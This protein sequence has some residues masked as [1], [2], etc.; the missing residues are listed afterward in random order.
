MAECRIVCY[1]PG[2]DLMV[3]TFQTVIIGSG[4]AGLNCAEHLHELGVHDIAIVTDRLGAGT[5]ANSG[6]DKQTYYK[7]G[8][9]G[10]VPDSPVQFARTLTEGGMCHGD[11]AYV[12][13][14]G[15]VPEFVHLVRNGV[16]FP[17]NE[18]G[19]YVG[20]KTDHDPRQRAT[21]AGP[22]TSMQMVAKSLDQVRRAAIPIFDGFEVVR[23]LTEGHG[24][25]KRIVGALAVEKAR[26]D[27]GTFGLTVF[28]AENVVLATGGPGE[29]YEAS[30][31]PPGQTGGLGLALEIGCVAHNLTESQFGIAS[32]GFRW[33]LSGTYQQVIPCYFSVDGD[34]GSGRNASST[35]Y[36]LNDYFPSMKAEAT[37]IFLKGC[38]WPFHAERLRDC[39]SSVIDI[40]VHNE[41]A[42]GRQ[43]YLDFSR[44]P[45]ADQGLEEFSPDDLEPEARDYLAACGADQPTPYE[46]LRHV[47]PQAI[48]LYAE[49][50]VDLREPLEIAVCAQHHNGGLRTNTWWETSLRHL[51]AI[52]EVCGTHG[53]RPGGSAL[54]AG[55][56]GGLRAAQYIARVH[57]G[58][59]RDA[60]T[61]GRLVAE[62]VC[63][64]YERLSSW[65]PGPGTPAPT[66]GEVRQEI[67]R[68]MTRCAAFLRS[69]EAV[70]QALLE[71]RAQ[72]ARLQE[73]GIRLTSREQMLIAVQNE[74]LCLAQIAFLTALDAYIT[75]GGGSR[76]SSVIL[77]E[78]DAPEGNV[79]YMETKR[80]RELR[81][82][83]ENMSMRDEILEIALSAEGE[84]EVHPVPVRP[85]PDDRS[86]YETTWREWIS[87][88]V[89]RR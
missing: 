60:D 83:V 67:Q 13:A 48:D 41:I 46:R 16:A 50:G 47:N 68:R 54:N 72:W 4:A 73:A 22:K 81:H 43:V 19:A 57:N 63:A 9:F 7:L 78:D 87:G 29:L 74:H 3:Y 25:T 21:S 69:R 44:N 77:A 89:F 79:Q 5:S 88:E 38:Q 71:A 51:F 52:G 86:W 40:A 45:V 33:N 49:H 12:E 42:A 39:G 24:E 31:Y 75:R 65:L 23:L 62:Q 37:A 85:I 84:F 70:G 59:P 1:G 18:F 28:N 66:P 55:Q 8:V 30:V 36:F 10:D 58:A 80:G 20:Y 82:L 64:E 76:G 35:R 27:E 26:I 34:D 14:L 6:S 56:V 11:I 53:I 32:T 15:S 17:H 2:C 61:V